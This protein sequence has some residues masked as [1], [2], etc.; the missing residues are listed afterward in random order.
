MKQPHL[1]AALAIIL[2][3]Q[4]A[5]V[6]GTPANSPANASA[7]TWSLNGAITLTANNDSVSES[8]ASITLTAIRS[9]GTQG[10]VSVSYKT[11]N[12]TAIAGTDYTAVAGT[13]TWAAGD[14][15]N[16]TFTIPVLNTKTFSG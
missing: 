5:F 6:V 10:A 1:P 13:L 16:K 2:S 11:V 15:A 4:I 7:A 14:K 9:G 12:E 8:S 3:G